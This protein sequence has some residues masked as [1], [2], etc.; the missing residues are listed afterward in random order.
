MT[1]AHASDIAHC[2][3][4]SILGLSSYE[5]GGMLITL[6]DGQSRYSQLTGEEIEVQRCQVTCLRSHS[7]RIPA[8]ALVCA[9][10]PTSHSQPLLHS[11][12]QNQVDGLLDK[13]G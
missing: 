8:P 3:M 6:A 4:G 9:L 2:V 12:A 5:Q 10:P 7:I 11:L 13:P 1:E